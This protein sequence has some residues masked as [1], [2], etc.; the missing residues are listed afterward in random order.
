MASAREAALLA[1][2][3]IEYEGAYSNI[4][5][6]DILNKKIADERDRALASAIVYGVCAHKLTLDYYISELSAVKLKKISKYI[7]QILRMGI[8]QI[9]YMDKIP[10]SAAV[11]ESVRLAR[12]YGHKAS[13]GYV[14]GVLRAACKKELAP[15]KDAY[16]RYSFA[17]EIQDRLFAD[18]GERAE[19]IMQA[20]NREPKMTIRAN[21]LKISRE[22][23]TE[24]LGAKACPLAPE[25]LYVKRLDTAASREFADG[26]FTV[27]DASP[28]AA[29]L[30]LD[31]KSG[32]NVID[33]CAAP[34]G[35]TT[36]IAELM[37][38]CGKITAFDIHEHRAELIRKNA[39]RLGI[40]IIEAVQQDAAVFREELAQSA[41][42]VLADVPCSGLGIAR[43]K[44]ELKYKTDTG[45]L[46]DIQLSI[47]KC[48]A[49]Y[50]KPGGV[51]VYSTCTIFKSENKDVI[52]K[53]LAEN[54]G[55]SPESMQKFLPDG[56]SED[57]PGF[58]TVLPD[59]VDCDGFFI[60]RLRKRK[61]EK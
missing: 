36:Y 27:Q 57:E 18:Y 16:L 21:T 37:Q 39:A 45:E 58:M 51:L 42:R 46:P 13:A 48:A 30:A 61:L 56:F 52:D 17:K 50:V 9:K 33:V 41:D 20:L 12:R 6:K 19:S 5:L 34:G 10:Q 25:A 26:L 43:R 29:C 24:K 7:L 49:K 44:P 59:E 2:Y 53:F 1:L 3:G 14:N 4:A 28:M 31:V 60:A 8:Y 35:K 38:N 15:P 32:Q 40:N 47:L 55:F 23:L 54:K 22:E 11:N